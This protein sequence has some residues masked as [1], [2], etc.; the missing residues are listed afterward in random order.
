MHAGQIIDQV[1][2]EEGFPDEELATWLGFAHPGCKGFGSVRIEALQQHFGS[3]SR[4]W[5]APRSEL[6]A[7]TDLPPGLVADL[8]EQRPKINPEQLLEEC[9]SQSITII[10][11]LHPQYPYRLR[12]VTDRPAVLFWKG[13]PPSAF[14]NKLEM[15][16]AIVGTRRPTA[17]GQK[18][19]KE[20]ARSIARLQITIVSGMAIGIDSF[21]HRGAIEGG[22]K[23]IA[24]LGSGVDICYPSSNRPLYELL[25]N[26]QHGA[27]ISEYFPG[28]TPDRWTFPARNRIISGICKGTCIIEGGSE[29]GALIT[30]RLALDQCREVFALPG[31]IDSPMSQGPNSLLREPS[32]HW[33]QGYEDILKELGWAASANKETPA[34]MELYGRE[35]EVYELLSTE[36]VCFDSLMERTGMT[37]GELSAT[38]AMLELGGTITRL[39]G[40]S[41][42]R[43]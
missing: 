24:V 14:G 35:K 19:A 37:A 17:Y 34:V 25:V 31:K 5:R 10:P 30:A 21:A 6:L 11:S 12:Q 18:Y 13:A 41:Y 28:T 2:P 38:L 29:S 39:P 7:V 4:A 32:A 43:T 26:G 36:P 9:R 40:D 27:V 8:V 1:I 42:A 23:T 3:L 16:L 33:V 22:G 15:A 20:I